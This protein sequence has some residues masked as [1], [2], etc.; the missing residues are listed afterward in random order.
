MT[1]SGSENSNRFKHRKRLPYRICL[2]HYY[3]EITSRKVCCLICRLAFFL[4]TSNVLFQNYR[5]MRSCGRDFSTPRGCQ[6]LWRQLATLSLVYPLSTP[7]WGLNSTAW[8]DE[9]LVELSAGSAVELLCTKA[10]TAER[11]ARAL[12]ARVH[13]YTCINSLASF[14]S[15]KVSLKSEGECLQNQVQRLHTGLRNPL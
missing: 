6:R 10:I 11:Y 7:A 13:N 15:E 3:T 5:G 9:Q 12:L 2:L 8:S 14:D 1:S 4:A